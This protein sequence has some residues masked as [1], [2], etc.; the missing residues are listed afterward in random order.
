MNLSTLLVIIIVGSASAYFLGYTRS[1]QIAKPIGGVR[2]LATLPS[3]YASMVGLWALIPALILVVLWS[4]LDG[5][6]I[7]SLVKSSLPDEVKQL[8]AENLSLV[9]SQVQNVASGIG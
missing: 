5:S 3:Y 7:S 9:M 6:V 8:S 2:N 1:Q 4:V